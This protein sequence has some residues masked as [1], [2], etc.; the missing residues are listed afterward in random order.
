MTAAD[1][2]ERTGSFGDLP[3]EEPFPG[4][5][6]HSFTTAQATVS[7]YTFEPGATFPRHRHPQ[8]QITMIVQGSVEMVIGDGSSPLRAGEWSVV[9]P[10]VEHGI[11]AGAEGAEFLA[12]VAP[13]RSG[14]D[15]YEI[16]TGA[17]P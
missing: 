10:D 11:T 1:A 3:S 2:A 5:R 6:R 16:R 8:E 13:P 7:R 12:I 17:E 14:S 4:V 9:G 15:E